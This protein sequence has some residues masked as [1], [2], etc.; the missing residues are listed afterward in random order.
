MMCPHCGKAIED[1]AE[2][3][4]HC[5]EKTLFA[6]RMHFM[7]NDA[8]EIIRG[9]LP[10]S[11]APAAKSGGKRPEPPKAAE[12]AKPAVSEKEIRLQ[13]ENAALKQ[14]VSELYEEKKQ[15]RFTA[16]CLAVACGLL[17]LLLL[18]VSGQKRSLNKELE[19]KNTEEVTG[20]M[21]VQSV[22]PAAEAAPTPTP[23]PAPTPEPTPEPTPA[24]T[25]EPTPEPAPEPTPEPTPIPES[26]EPRNEPP[27]TMPDEGGFPQPKEP[28]DG[29]DPF[30]DGAEVKTDTIL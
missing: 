3:C 28:S 20:R 16:L 13:K 14:R 11:A 25:P 19:R 12:S 24:P 26:P 18:I 15:E 2:K 27:A 8:P 17:L 23:T 10:P 5:G 29:P 6:V 4:P 1:R 22:L 7:E 21:A 30:P 9:I